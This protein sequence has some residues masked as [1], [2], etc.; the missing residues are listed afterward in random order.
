MITSSVPFPFLYAQFNMCVVRALAE[1]IVRGAVGLSTLDRTGI[2]GV[3]KVLQAMCRTRHKESHAA[4]R[5]LSLITGILP[6]VARLNFDSVKENLMALLIP[7]LFSTSRNKYGVKVYSQLIKSVA[8]FTKFDPTGV[9]ARWQPKKEEGRTAVSEE[10]IFHLKSPFHEIRMSCAGYVGLL[11]H[12][13]V[14]PVSVQWHKRSYEKVCAA[15]M[16]SF[17]VEGD[18]SREEKIDEGANRTASAMHTMA[19]MVVVCPAWRRKAL[20]MI[21]QLVHEKNISFELVCKVLRLVGEHLKLQEC[22]QLVKV[23]AS[24]LVHHWMEQEYQLQKFPWQLMGCV[25]ITQ[26]YRQYKDIIVPIL[27]QREEEEETLTHV[28]QKVGKNVRELVEGCFPHS[29]AC[30]LPYIASNDSTDSSSITEAEKNTSKCLH[31]Q[32]ERILGGDAINTLITMRIDEVIVNVIR[33]LYDPRHFSEL[34]GCQMTLPEPIPPVLNHSMVMKVVEHLQESCPDSSVAL[35]ST[36]SQRVPHQLQRILLPLASDIHHAPTQEDK[37]QAFHRYATF[38]DILAEQLTMPV[39]LHTM[40]LFVVRDVIYTLI[41]L[42]RGG[43]LL[44]DPLC[45]FFHR[46]C[47]M[48]LPSRS[49]CL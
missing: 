20:F 43:G 26:F 15:V 45:H 1:T 42:L 17:V 22:S 36:L 47:S 24:Y 49:V 25:S 3:L 8:E 29:M 31:N 41:H 12:S 30:L 40:N 34:C 37:L 38:A 18:L 4:Y 19:T 13:S 27:L 39:G 11:F 48:I 7:F 28:S 32:L 44:F 21:F 33:L 5:L 10:L 16:E 9:W 6:H 2:E 23:N 46:F 35:V 14:T